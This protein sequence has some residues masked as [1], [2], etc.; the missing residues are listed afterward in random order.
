MRAAGLAIAA[1]SIVAAGC[2]ASQGDAD[3]AF[4][5]VES[6]ITA[7][8]AEAL[9]FAPDAFAAVMERYAAARREY[10][11]KD[12]DAAIEGVEAALARARQLPS[13]IAEGRERVIAAWPATRDS[14]DRMLTALERRLTEVARTRHYPSGLGAADL[15]EVQGMLDSLNAS[16]QRASGAFEAGDLAAALHAAERVG[17]GA[18]GLE[19]RLGMRLGNPDGVTGHGR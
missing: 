11:A 2:A 19:T 10:E 1:A 9:R 13:V 15:A 7:Q 6:V 3:A 5:E 16:W 8:H 18:A 14:I 17:Q 4:R 12:W